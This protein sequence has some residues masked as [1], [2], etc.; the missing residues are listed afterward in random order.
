[1][2]GERAYVTF[3]YQ[4]IAIVFLSDRL[5]RELVE[6]LTEESVIRQGKKHV[7]SSGTVS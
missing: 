3:S 7:M 5:W 1:V 2:L 6:S 4:N